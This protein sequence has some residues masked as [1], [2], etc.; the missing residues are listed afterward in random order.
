MT[1]AGNRPRF[2][3]GSP[4]DPLTCV[5]FASMRRWQVLNP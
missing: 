3:G 2:G 1:G 4:G 5:K